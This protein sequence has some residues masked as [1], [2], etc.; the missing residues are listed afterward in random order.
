M[1]AA[2]SQAAFLWEETCDG[3]KGSGRELRRGKGLGSVGGLQ[4]GA[5]PGVALD[6]VVFSLPSNSHRPSGADP[7][8]AVSGSPQC[9][10]LSRLWTGARELV[11]S[12]DSQSRRTEFMGQVPR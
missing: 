5:G 9:G 10:S 6:C 8:V 12:P 4:P 3:R 11:G 1:S 7:F 2:T